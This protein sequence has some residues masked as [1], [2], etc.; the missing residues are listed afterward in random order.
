MLS[1]E[2]PLTE[3]LTF[4]MTPGF[5]IFYKY[6]FR[7]VLMNSFILRSFNID[8]TFCRQTIYT[9]QW[10]LFIFDLLL[11]F[12]QNNICFIQFNS[13]RSIHLYMIVYPLFVLCNT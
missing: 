4:F 10:G 2:L 9:Q 8:P 3:I 5:L 12:I 1:F 7:V 6:L 11:S 13:F